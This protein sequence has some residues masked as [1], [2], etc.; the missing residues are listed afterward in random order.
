M[1]DFIFIKGKNPN[2][3]RAEIVS[4]LESREILYE[5][6]DDNRYFIVL[7]FSEQVNLEVMMELLGGTL[8]IIQILSEGK[9]EE[10]EE[11]MKKVEIENIVKKQKSVFG[12]SV[13]STKDSHKIYNTMGKHFKKRLK[14]KGINSSFFGFSRKKPQLTNVEI[15]K[16]RLIEES[17]EIILCSNGKN[18]YIGLTK[19]IHNPF[20]FQK[21]DIGRPAQRTI[22][23]MTSL[24]IPYHQ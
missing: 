11:L 22:Y 8:K 9:L 23:S 15:I 14:D 5:I 2:L 3:S 7:H 24:F 4:Y 13:Y 21:R 19:F 17:A 6:K 1:Q 16:K 12:I 10:L 20:E 18:T